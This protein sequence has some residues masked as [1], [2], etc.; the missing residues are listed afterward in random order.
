[1]AAGVR[2]LPFE[3]FA[4]ARNAAGTMPRHAF[5]ALTKCRIFARTGPPRLTRS[6]V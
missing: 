2:D 3:S 1:M 4:R 6:L 5:D